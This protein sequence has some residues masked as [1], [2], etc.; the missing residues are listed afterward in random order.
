MDSFAW[1]LTLRV[2][3][4][5]SRHCAR[6]ETFHLNT[7]LFTCSEQGPPRAGM[8][9]RSAASPHDAHNAV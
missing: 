9:L 5:L 6:S 8:S 2:H 1:D 4:R 3:E 7:A